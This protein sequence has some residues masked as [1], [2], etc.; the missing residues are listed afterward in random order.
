MVTHPDINATDLPT[1]ITRVRTGDQVNQTIKVDVV[2]DV[3]QHELIGI[4]AAPPS[5]GHVPAAGAPVTIST[6]TN[7]LAPRWLLDINSQTLE[8]RLLFLVGRDSPNNGYRLSYRTRAAPFGGAFTAEQLDGDFTSFTRYGTL[9][10]IGSPEV[11][12]GYMQDTAN[13]GLGGGGKGQD[14]YVD[15]TGLSSLVG[16]YNPAGAFDGLIVINPRGA[17]EEFVAMTTCTP[18]GTGIKCSGVIRGIGDTPIQQHDPGEPV[19]FIDTN[20]YLQPNA[21]PA[22]TN[23]SFGFQ[24]KIGP[25]APDG[26]GTITGYQGEQKV[27]AARYNKPY[28]PTSLQFYAISTTTW[29]PN[30]SILAWRPTSFN[31][32]SLDGVDVY[33][34]NRRFDQANPIYGA[35]SADDG[36]IGYSTNTFADYNPTLKWWLY[37]VDAFPSPARTD[38]FASGTE[39]GLDDRFNNKRFGE[40]LFNDEL[41]G[42]TS[43]F[44]CRF[45]F[46]WENAGSPLVDPL[47]PSGVE[48]NSVYQDHRIYFYPGEF[49]YDVVAE[50]ALLIHFDGPDRTQCAIDESPY[51]HPVT[52]SGIAE[53][54][55][56]ES[57]LD[58]SL[59]ESS[60][61]YRPYPF[62]PFGSPET[63]VEVTDVSPQA[64]D[65]DNDRGYVIQ[66]RVKFSA[67]PSGLIPLITKWRESDN[68][69]AFWLGF[70]GAGCRL[71]TSLDG[72]TETTVTT[73]GKT[74]SVGQWYDIRVEVIPSS[75]NLYAVFFFDGLRHQAFINGALSG[76][77]HLS[78]APLRIGSDG[79]GVH[80]SQSIHID[81]VRIV[82]APIYGRNTGVPTTEFPGRN[83]YKVLHCN[84]ENATGS[85]ESTVYN[86]DDLNNY[87][88]DFPANEVTAVTSEQSKFGTNSLFCGGVNATGFSNS[89]G[90]RIA[91]TSS[92]GT[93]AN[94]FHFAD[95]DITMEGFVRFNVLPVSHTGSAVSLIVK[96]NRGAGVFRNWTLLLSKATTPSLSF[97][98]RNEAGTDFSIS[99]ST[100]S[101]NVAIN[102]WYHFAFVRKDGAA[103]LFWEG[104]RVAFNATVLDFPFLNHHDSDVTLGRMESNTTSDHWVLNGWL[105]EIRIFNGTAEY[106]PN[107]TS[108][109]VPVAAFPVDPVCGPYVP[110]SPQSPVTP[111]SPTS[112]I[113]VRASIWRTVELDTNKFVG[114]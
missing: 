41:S 113:Q 18:D 47:V 69:R 92:I 60:L 33:V 98:Y 34:G 101:P 53:L 105:D 38:A 23:D 2:E 26:V 109:T 76:T 114:E 59:G 35:N 112:P 27:D 3:F 56:N 110:P 86:T 79:D 90:V 10:G 22:D 65:L 7:T 19:F 58:G 82:K 54:D 44:N 74:W 13:D 61:W 16:T 108:L 39:A 32:F 96:R 84:W 66:F 64:F 78:A 95:R 24:Y 9:R 28:P 63:F 85:P 45:E 67:T 30:G 55:S 11:G 89:D 104:Q 21:Y 71:I 75:N 77:L 91:G 73:T 100:G 94:N 93:Y 20:T 25:L 6:H 88:V 68:E 8:P 17:N 5:S 15:G 50:T 51:N 14:F 106:D 12:L 42:L 81:E 48:S 4:A 31:T 40:E 102:T 52:I 72:I 36:G 37:D 46:A 49:T 70:S 103:A 80:S 107:L 99:G 83:R 29:Y 43:G 111:P 62:S 87:T 97:T 57:P 1:R